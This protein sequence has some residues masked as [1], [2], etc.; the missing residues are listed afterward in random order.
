MCARRENT[1]KIIVLIHRCYK[2][3]QK[4]K[5][6]CERHAKLSY[7][8][9]KLLPTYLKTNGKEN[10]E[11]WSNILWQWEIY[12]TKKLL[13]HSKGDRKIVKLHKILWYCNY[14]GWG[15]GFDGG[16]T[17]PDATARTFPALWFEAPSKKLTHWATNSPPS[18]AQW[19]DLINRRFDCRQWNNS[20]ACQQMN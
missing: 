19:L 9:I 15:G 6:T 8:I 1:T 17:C 13:S 3:I 5:K 18:P 2:T 16:T 20:P 4:I 10:T 12:F 14:V 11:K 7:T